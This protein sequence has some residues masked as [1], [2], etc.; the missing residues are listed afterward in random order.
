MPVKIPIGHAGRGAE[1]CSGTRES[2]FPARASGPCRLRVWHC[3][4]LPFATPAAEAR[5][6]PSSLLHLH[7][8]SSS[9]FCLLPTSTDAQSNTGQESPSLALSCRLKDLRRKG[10]LRLFLIMFFSVFVH[11][12]VHTS[13]GANGGQK[14]AL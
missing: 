12:Y 1:R 2:E 11:E 8:G 14:R 9:P 13:A 5:K 10:L 4:V 3:R 7:I 6:R